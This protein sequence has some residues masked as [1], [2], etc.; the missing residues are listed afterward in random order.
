MTTGRSKT[1]L[2]LETSVGLIWAL[3]LM[4]PYLFY[5]SRKQTFQTGPNIWADPHFVRRVKSEEY[6]ILIFSPKKNEARYKNEPKELGEENLYRL[7]E[8]RPKKTD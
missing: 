4:G 8:H 3:N 5:L 1:R 7:D 2:G 6:N